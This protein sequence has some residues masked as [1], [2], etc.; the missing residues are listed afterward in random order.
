M[1][2]LPLCK[3]IVSDVIQ[4]VD[5]EQSRICYVQ[6]DA[7]HNVLPGEIDKNKMFKIPYG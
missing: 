2:M 7:I 3:I 6:L 4:S 1:E 5:G